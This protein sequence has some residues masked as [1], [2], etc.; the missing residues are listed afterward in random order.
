MMSSFLATAIKTTLCGVACLSPSAVL[1][2]CAVPG[3]GLKQQV[4]LFVCQSNGPSRVNHQSSLPLEQGLYQVW[5][6]QSDAHLSDQSWPILRWPGKMNVHAL[7]TPGVHQSLYRS[8][9]A[10]PPIHTLLWVPEQ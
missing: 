9:L 6:A 2:K 3:C 8:G 10:I 5:I 1:Q 7:L 4:R